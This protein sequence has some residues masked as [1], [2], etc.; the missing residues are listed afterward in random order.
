MYSYYKDDYNDDDIHPPDMSGYYE[1]IKG[2]LCG[3]TPFDNLWVDDRRL[4]IVRDVGWMDY[5]DLEGIKRWMKALGWVWVDGG[6][7]IREEMYEKD[8]EEFRELME[9][10]ESE[11]Y[12]RD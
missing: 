5:K 9:L 8:Y 12:E 1:R 2:V 6:W 7:W 3:N 4:K 11:Y 10:P